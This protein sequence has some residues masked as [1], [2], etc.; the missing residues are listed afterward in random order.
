MHPHQYRVVYLFEAHTIFVWRRS[1]AL[2]QKWKCD[3]HERL[4]TGLPENCFK[5]NVNLKPGLVQAL[6]EFFLSQDPETRLLP[7][8]RP[9]DMARPSVHARPILEL[10]S[11]ESDDS[12]ESNPTEESSEGPLE[13]EDDSLESDASESDYEQPKSKKKSKQKVSPAKRCAS[14]TRRTDRLNT[15]PLKKHKASRN[16]GN[17]VTIDLTEGS[18]PNDKAKQRN[19]ATTTPATIDLSEDVIEAAQS[20]SAA[21]STASDA[22]RVGRQITID[23]TNNLEKNVESHARALTK[24]DFKAKLDDE[25]RQILADNRL[26]SLTLHR[27]HSILSK[28]LSIDMNEHRELIRKLVQRTVT[29]SRP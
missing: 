9:S 20:P 1:G 3:D 16:E 25:I 27:V 19:G 15:T 8:M 28:K 7:K 21:A 18:H 12:S 11:E 17:Q 26:E 23:L 29:S 2:L 14:T 24:A 13:E 6:N 10:S 4:C 22:P 5:T